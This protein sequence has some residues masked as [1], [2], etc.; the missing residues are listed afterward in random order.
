MAFEMGVLARN[1]KKYRA[2]KN[3][4][5]Q[6][7]AERLNVSPQSVSKWECGQSV[8]EIDKLCSVAEILEVSLDALVEALIERNHLS[9]AELEQV[10]QEAE[11]K[12]V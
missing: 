6:A 7:L 1:L 4:T 12:G 9:A 3:L 10:F 5:Q 11:K 2:E 8:P